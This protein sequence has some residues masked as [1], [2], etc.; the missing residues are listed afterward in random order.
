VTRQ[1][2]LAI[3]SNVS[4]GLRAP[5]SLFSILK[6]WRKKTRRPAAYRTAWKKGMATLVV[7]R[8]VES[9]S[10]RAGDIGVIT[11]Y[12]AQTSLIKAMLQSQ[13]LG[14]VEAANIDAS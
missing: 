13:S 2:A 9:G 11:P 3:E 14:D 10:V 6:V 1:F 4:Q 8:L 12:E 5:R 7:K